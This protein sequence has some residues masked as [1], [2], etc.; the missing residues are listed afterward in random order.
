M[1]RYFMVNGPL[2]GNMGTPPVEPQPPQVSFTTTAESRGGFN[3]FLKSIPQ[4]TAMTPIPPLG[5]A[6]TAPMSNPMGNIDIFNQPPSMGMGMMGMNQPQMQQPMQPPMQQP[7]NMGV[8]LMGKP[9]QNFFDGGGVDDSDFGGFSDYGSVDATSDDGFSEDNDVSDYSTDDSGVYTGGDDSNQDIALPTPRPEILKEA[10]GRAENQV[11][12]DTEGDALG[13]FNKSGGLTDAGQK[14]YDNAIMANLDVLQDERPANTG[15]QLA[16]VFDD[17][18]ILGDSTNNVN[19]ADIVQAS[20]KPGSLNPTFSNNVLD[21]LDLSASLGQNRNRNVEPEAFDMFGNP[22]STLTNQ[23]GVSISNRA[24]QQM[25]DN[26]LADRAFSEGNFSMIGPADEEYPG[27]AFPGKALTTQNVSPQNTADRIARNNRSINEIR[28]GIESGNDDIYTDSVPNLYDPPEEDP[29]YNPNVPSLAYQGYNP[30][31]DE[32]YNP[33][34]PSTLDVNSPRGFTPLDID[35][36]PVN[37]AGFRD[38]DFVFDPANYNMDAMSTNVVPGIGALTPDEKS[39]LGGDPSNMVEAGGMGIPA[40]KEFR[41]P[42]PNAGIG[43]IP[44]LTSLA[45][46]FSAYSR[47]RVLDSIAQKGYTPVYDGDVIV[48][49][50]NKSGQLME[51]MDPNA[52]MDTGND[53]NENP[54]ILRPIAKAPEEEKEEEKLPNVIGGGETP[55]PV[56]SGSVVVD[57]PFTSNVGNFI[58]SSFN[59]GELNK[60]IEALTGVSAPRAMKQGGVAGYAEGGRV[61]QAL[62][63]LLATG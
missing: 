46:K 25:V 50:K 21:G 17:Q 44:T 32:G 9:I 62:D 23:P 36:R 40:P 12:G 3:N 48:G 45:N 22:M 58:P 14:E 59:T 5:S 28:A 34:V 10:V 49:A 60:L 37:Q 43:A 31:L 6:P 11:F 1:R 2:G 39:K 54:L 13:F 29:N 52:P 30:N 33:N 41:D 19:P 27:D 55:A 20:F 26:D 56:S 61:M 8:G 47:G 7:M 51:G 63:N 53:N 24:M 42:F 35:T 18:S 16:N 15:I 38:T 4:T 57:S